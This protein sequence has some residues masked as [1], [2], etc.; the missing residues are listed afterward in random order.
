MRERI[1]CSF[2]GCPVSIGEKNNVCPCCGTEYNAEGHFVACRVKEARSI[3]CYECGRKVRLVDSCSNRCAC[4]AEY[5]LFGGL[6]VSRKQ[7]NK[8]MDEMWS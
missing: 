6:V 3:A 1:V 2:C 5:D 7:W 8:E 4:G